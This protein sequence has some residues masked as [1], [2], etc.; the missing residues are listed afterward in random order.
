MMKGVLTLASRESAARFDDG[1]GAVRRH[2]RSVR[3]AGVAMPQ[4]RSRPDSAAGQALADSCGGHDHVDERTGIVAR[5]DRV[6][7]D[8]ALVSEACGVRAD[9][10]HPIPPLIGKSGNAAVNS[11]AR[12]AW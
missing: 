5:I 12:G 10:V 11:A 8:R 2:G 3:L 4:H 6:A 9:L 7:R 1:N